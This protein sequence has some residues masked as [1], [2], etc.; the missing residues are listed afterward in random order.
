MQPR[1]EPKLF[2]SYFLLTKKVSLRAIV[3]I[4]SVKNK[5]GFR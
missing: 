1:S 2:Q 5:Y 4:K 3:E